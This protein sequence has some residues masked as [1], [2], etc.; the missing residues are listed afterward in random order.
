MCISDPLRFNVFHMDKLSIRNIEMDM[1]NLGIP[2]IYSQT[3]LQ[4]FHSIMR[5][6]WNLFYFQ[7]R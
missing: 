7:V 2:A 1:L 5:H 6:Y 4:R 3:T